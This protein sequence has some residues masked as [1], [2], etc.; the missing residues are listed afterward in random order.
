LA[1]SGELDVPL[2]LTGL[3]LAAFV[4]RLVLA[5]RIATPWIMVDELIYSEL[6]KSFAESGDF[7]IRGTTSGFRNLAYPALI[8]PAWWADSIESAYAF[9]RAINTALM[10]LTAIPVYLWGRRLMSS[11]YALLAAVLV[12]LMPSLNYSG[13]LM[14]ENAFFIAFVGAC[15]AIAVTLERPTLIN[16]LLALATIA[17]ASLARPQGL[18][19]VGVYALALALK[20]GLD[21]R[22][23]G[24]GGGFRYVARQLVRYTPTAVIALLLGGAYVLYAS[25]QGSGLDT[26]LGAY[27]GVVKVEYDLG[28]ASDWVV[29]HFAELTLSV[30]VI[31]I[32]ALIV[33]LGGAVRGWATSE[34]E[35]AFLAVTA[36]AFVL[37]VVQVGIYASRFSLRIEERNMFCVAP[38]LFLALALWLGRGLPRP[39]LLT[40]VAAAGPAAL[41]LALDLK[42]LLQIGVLSDTF[43]LIPLFKASSRLDGGVET[44][45]VLMLGAG[46]AA[47]VAFA[48]VPRRIAAAVLPAGVALFLCVWSYSVFTSI[49]DHSRATLALTV[50]SDPS[51]I[52][53]R[54]GRDSDATYVYGQSP[55]P[56]GE[57]QVMWQT[58]FWNRSVKSIYAIGFPDPA[59]L[60]GTSAATFDPVTGRISTADPNTRPVLYAVA[61]TMTQLNGKLLRQEGRLAL[62]RV[63]PP[64]RFATHFGGVYADSWMGSFAAYTHYA[65][66]LRPGRLHVRVSREG[67]GQPSPAGRVT[68][69]LGPLVD[70]GGQPAVGRPAESRTWT[71]R[72]GRAKS[73]A[74]PTPRAPYRLEVRVEPTFSPA[75]YGQ[76]DTRQL[77]AQLYVSGG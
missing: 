67:W 60:P 72:S 57:A 51:W 19:L 52:D 71:V 77:G 73:F 21:L 53:E 23:P 18:V 1:R 35:R 15:F 36:S 70:A 24:A 38:L 9:A 30:A 65:M 42:S 14:T 59:S 62:Y 54:I 20:L 43:A 56:Y 31:P 68:L 69:T 33:L 12:L 11:G 49:R 32:S 61:P 26:L 64:L 74:L 8:A 50:P 47:G 29:D 41:L 37:T 39:V 16:Q 75:D 45:R 66:P 5:E 27:G 7:L 13:M 4:V 6:A 40:A 76:S 46:A 58:E 22:A 2:I 17:F 44:V 28:N 10:V 48:L 25:I 3:L 63:R 34:A 55:D